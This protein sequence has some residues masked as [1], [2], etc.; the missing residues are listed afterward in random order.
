MKLIPSTAL[1]YGG[2]S[3]GLDL[4]EDSLQ[5]PMAS[6]TNTIKPTANLSS[7]NIAAN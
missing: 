3:V 7:L 6:I 5:A 1:K 4:F 2:S